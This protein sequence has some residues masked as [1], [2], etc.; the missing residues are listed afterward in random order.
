MQ[1]QNKRSS[2]L[3]SIAWVALAGLALV[4]LAGTLDWAAGHLGNLLC[5]ILGAGLSVISSLVLSTLQRILALASS[6]C[7]FQDGFPRLLSSLP[8]LFLMTGAV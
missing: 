8:A 2:N 3:N 1:S 4:S 7:W 6:Q 5:D